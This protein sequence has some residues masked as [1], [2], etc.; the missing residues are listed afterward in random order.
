MVLASIDIGS[1]SV[2]LLIG[3]VRDGEVEV[4]FTDRVVTRLARGLSVSSVLGDSE[5]KMTLEV[6]EGFKRKAKAMGAEAIKAVATSAIR[7]ARNSE[8]FLKDVLLK[9]G[10]EIEVISGDMEAELTVL[11]VLSGLNVSSALI[12]DIGGGSTEWAYTKGGRIFSKGSIPIGVVK[13]Y[14][15]HI[16]S[17]PPSREDIMSLDLEIDKAVSSIKDGVGD[18]EPKTEFIAT[19][20]TASTL[21]SLDLSIERYDR[22]LIHG[23]RIYIDRLREISQRLISLP[24]KERESLKGLEPSRAD[25]IIPGINFTIKIMEKF[26]FKKVIISENGLLEGALLNLA[27]GVQD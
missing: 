10:L 8:E 22:N 24:I 19:A 26:G 15:R 23:H 5:M 18:L 25:L 20:G 3:K 1:N 2:R 9:T 14:E 13:L 16:D 17:E 11:G 21:A 6:L 27:K 4:L 12:V 7:E